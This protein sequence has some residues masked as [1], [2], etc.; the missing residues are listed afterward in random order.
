MRKAHRPKGELRHAVAV[1]QLMAEGRTV[2]QIA[3]QM[4]VT[5]YWVRKHWHTIRAELGAANRPHAVVLAW[6][7]G[8]VR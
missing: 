7:K 1:L 5:R 3:A 6:R 8:W 2:D 4:G